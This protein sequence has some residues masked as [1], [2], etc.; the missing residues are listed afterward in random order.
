MYEFSIPP[1]CHTQDISYTRFNG[2][3]LPALPLI[4]SIAVD[5]QT[6]FTN[7]AMHGNPNQK[8]LAA[9]P[10][11]ANQGNMPNLTTSGYHV[12]SDP[13]RM[14]RRKSWEKYNVVERALKRVGEFCGDDCQRFDRSNR[15][16]TACVYVMT[17][18]L[19]LRS[20]RPAQDSLPSEW[21][22]PSFAVDAANFTS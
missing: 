1:A 19:F 5:M 3:N 20:A 16:R 6:C 17:L 4:P 15:L 21:I 2:H 14:Q 11:F 8:G 22:L 18:T 10:I 12:V 9:M 7:F 13:A